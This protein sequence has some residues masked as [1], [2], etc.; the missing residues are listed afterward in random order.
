MGIEQIIEESSDRT[1]KIAGTTLGLV[2]GGVLGFLETAVFPSYTVSQ[3]TRD[4]RYPAYDAIWPGKD[5]PNGTKNI[6]E[7]R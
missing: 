5:F 4:D 1:R 7:Q 2:V 3:I 6:L